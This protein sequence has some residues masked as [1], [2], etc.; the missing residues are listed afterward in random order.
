MFVV[1][2]PRRF[3]FCINSGRSG[4]EY[5]A[6]L[7]G[8][9]ERVSAFH[10][11]KP[12]MSGHYLHMICHRGLEATFTERSIKAQAIWQIV[13]NLPPGWIYAETNHMFI[14]TF[15]DV[16]MEAF[17]D[18]E[19]DV[20]IL[21]RSLPQVLK[22]FI[23]MGYFSER[24]QIWP[25]W[26]SLPGTCN[27]AFQPPPA[28]RALDQYDLAIGYLLDIEARAQR[29]K[30]RYPDCRIHEIRLESLQNSDDMAD[31]FVAL[32]LSPTAATQDGLGRRINERSRRKAE[33]GIGT[34]LKYCEQRIEEYL[35]KCLNQG[36]EVPPLPHMTS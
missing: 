3:V 9:A 20:I 19:I 4:S 17:K 24:N 6:R 26:M 30:L 32:G 31:F 13:S 16:V 33:I 10:E 22:S 1:S 29:F 36:I 18:H 12:T 23:T 14:K 11:A 2:K 34:T 28:D 7:L 21:R 35:W 27:C 5:L 8:T 15:F 25:A